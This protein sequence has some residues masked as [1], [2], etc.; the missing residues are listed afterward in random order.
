MRYFVTFFFVHAQ[1]DDD[2]VPADPDQLLD[3][4][5]ATTGEFRE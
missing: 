1:D 4:S 5:D 2:F 3:R